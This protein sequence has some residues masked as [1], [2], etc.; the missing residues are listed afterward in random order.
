MNDPAYLF[1][2]AFKLAH[3]VSDASL[4]LDRDPGLRGHRSFADQLA[5]SGVSALAYV[6]AA[7]ADFAADP[8]F[9][10][11]HRVVTSLRG[12]RHELSQLRHSLK[13]LL[14]RRFLNE[15]SNEALLAR[16]DEATLVITALA[17]E[18][19]GSRAAA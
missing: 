2:L 16:V 17:I 19:T 10:G 14:G 9:R 8:S 5:D 13:S 7:S 15:A 6:A 3:E 18:L 1:Q 12:A 4:D 11:R